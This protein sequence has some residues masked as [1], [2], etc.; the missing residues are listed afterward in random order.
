MTQ[1]LK[2]IFHLP[3]RFSGKSAHNRAGFSRYWLAMKF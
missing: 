3:F 2:P 1:I